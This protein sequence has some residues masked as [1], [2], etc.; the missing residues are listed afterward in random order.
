MRTSFQIVSFH[1]TPSVL[2]LASRLTSFLICGS[3]VGLFLGGR[4]ALKTLKG[5]EKKTYFN[6]MASNIALVEE[7]PRRSCPCGKSL[8]I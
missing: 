1:F 6:A 4:G 7:E 2:P 8:C 3:M 5:T